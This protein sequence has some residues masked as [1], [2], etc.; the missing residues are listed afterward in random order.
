M[1]R[2]GDNLEKIKRNRMSGSISGSVLIMIMM[3]VIVIMTTNK[4]G[5]YAHGRTVVTLSFPL[6][7]S[8]KNAS[9]DGKWQF[10]TLWAVI[11]RKRCAIPLIPDRLQQGCLVQLRLSAWFMS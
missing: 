8:Q 5:N 6:E 9:R 1:T 4:S 3:M 7:I 11:A 2:P 10:I